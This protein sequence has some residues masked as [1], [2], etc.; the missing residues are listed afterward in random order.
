MACRSIQLCCLFL[1]LYT[2]LFA[3][4]A[5]SHFLGDFSVRAKRRPSCPDFC[6]IGDKK[7]ALG[8]KTCKQLGFGTV[9]CNVKEQIC[10]GVKCIQKTTVGWRCDCSSSCP[11][12][13]SPLP[14]SSPF[15]TD[16]F[17]RCAQKNCFVLDG[18]LNY[19]TLS[20]SLIGNKFICALERKPP[21]VI[22]VPKNSRVVKAVISWA[23]LGVPDST[24]AK[25]VVNGQSVKPQIF[26]PFSSENSYHALADVTDTLKSV[27]SD[28][29]EFGVSDMYYDPSV[30]PSGRCETDNFAAWVLYVAFETPTLPKS[31]VTVCGDSV[32]VGHTSGVVDYPP[33]YVQCL[34][35]DVKWIKARTTIVGFEG[36]TT[37]HDLYINDKLERSGAFSGRSETRLD[38]VDV[39]LKKFVTTRDKRVKFEVRNGGDGVLIGSWA[40]YQKA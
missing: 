27:A 30:A 22:K 38:V 24:R 31:R 13:S 26:K 28:T 19:T 18:R 1:S 8:R 5:R 6:F 11:T 33:F 3:S 21:S 4:T 29:Q 23:A 17:P 25:V 14:Q 20:G 37:K 7:K 2:F 10:S 36:E 16:L 35:P 12:V 9:T 15:P 40:S 39:D 32:V 34:I